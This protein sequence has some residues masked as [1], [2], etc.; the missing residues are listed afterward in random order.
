MIEGIMSYKE[1]NGINYSIIIPH[2]NIPDL[3]GR[4][5]RSIPERRD[6]QVIVVGKRPNLGPRGRYTFSAEVLK[7]FG[8]DTSNLPEGAK[9]IVRKGKK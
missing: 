6:I 5:L 9:A 8:V 4:C 2:Y 1:N 3:L 7:S